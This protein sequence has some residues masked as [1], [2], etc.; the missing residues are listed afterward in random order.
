MAYIF[1]DESGDLGFDF[2]KKNTSKFFVITILFTTDKKSIE[3]V[4]KNAHATLKK[5]HKQKGGVLHAYHEK[6]VT[7]KRLLS[8]LSEKEIMIP[9][10]STR[11]A[12]KGADEVAG[13][14]PSFFNRMGSMEPMTLPH[15][16]I[17]I[18]EKKIISAI[19]T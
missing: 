11:V 7:R 18:R 8:K 2:K 14:S 13:S 17:P 9:V 4:V 3:K 19:N 10:T 6:R 5:K 12:T 15:N 1:L 16:T